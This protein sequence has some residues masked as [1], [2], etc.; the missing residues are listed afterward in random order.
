[1]QSLQEL[2]LEVQRLE[3]QN[4]DLNQVVMPE[5]NHLKPNQT[6]SM[7]HLNQ[8]VQSAVEKARKDALKRDQILKYKKEALA[9]YE[10]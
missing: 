8:G 5:T 7:V 1:M 2:R 10:T 9:Q 4:E 6:K 3:K